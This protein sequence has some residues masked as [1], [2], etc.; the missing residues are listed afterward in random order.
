MEDA[1]HKRRL[2]VPEFGFPRANRS[3]DPA[4]TFY[5]VTDVEEYFVEIRATLTQ[6]TGLS[7]S[8]PSGT[9]IERSELVGGTRFSADYGAASQDCQL[10]RERFVRSGGP[11]SPW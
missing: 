5:A 6:H 10:N 7:E 3:F 1:H 4:A 9:E 11:W 2:F 8:P